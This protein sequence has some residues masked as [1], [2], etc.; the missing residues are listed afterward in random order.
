MSNRHLFRSV[1]LQT[2]FEWDF[3]NTKDSEVLGILNRNIKSFAEGSVDNNFAEKITKGV[4]D[5]KDAIDDIITKAAPQWPIERI[6]V[7]DRN[8]LRLGI[9]E[10]LFSDRKETPPKVAINEAI[11]LAKTFGGNSSGRFISGV[12]GTI[13]KELG[14]P[15]KDETGKKK[16][17]DVPY[18][19]MPIEK[20]AGAV[21][22]TEKDGEILLAFVHDIF[23]HWTISKGGIDDIKDEKEGVKR[24]LKEELG[25]DIT[26]GDKLGVNEYIANHPERGK[27]RRQV[28][29]FLANTE[30]KDLRLPEDSG[31]LDKAQW[32]KLADILDLNFYDDVVPF[33]TKAVEIFKNK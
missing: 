31:G 14:E 2:L 10:L 16:I 11:E 4:L 8:V 1:V 32:F 27:I 15:G 17:K 5:K 29:Y 33:V 22:Y 9:Y 19:E 23:G 13:Y 25:L 24:E 21:V 28:V 12:L 6:A 18:E 3:N 20:K 30:Y 26:V 7:I